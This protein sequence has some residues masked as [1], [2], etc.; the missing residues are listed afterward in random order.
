[1][2]TLS[3]DLKVAC[4][5]YRANISDTPI[6]FSKLVEIFSGKIERREVSHALDTL[7]DWMLIEGHYGSL[8]NGR[9]GYLYEIS[10]VSIPVIKRLYDIYISA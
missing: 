10:E 4:E 7:S 2:T 6:W 1:M 8:G 9:A 5:I 3:N